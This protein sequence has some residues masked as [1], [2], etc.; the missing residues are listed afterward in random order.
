M[1]DDSWCHDEAV[2]A[3][4]NSLKQPDLIQLHFE[5]VDGRTICQRNPWIIRWYHAYLHVLYPP[6]AKKN[7]QEIAN[8]INGLLYKLQPE[9]LKATKGRY[10]IGWD[11]P[12]A[13]QSPPGL[14]RRKLPFEALKLRIRRSRRKHPRQ[15]YRGGGDRGGVFFFQHPKVDLQRQVKKI[16]PFVGGI[17]LFCHMS[18]S[19]Y[20]GF[21]RFV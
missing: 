19:N 14:L 3:K 7:L 8:L 20:Q 10:S 11:A 9:S 4:K 2:G 17:K 12:P 18:Y 13:T 15:W 21:P 1:C 6:N 5:L 16:T